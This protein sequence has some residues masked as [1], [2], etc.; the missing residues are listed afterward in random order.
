MFKVFIIG[1]LYFGN[2]KCP[3]EVPSPG[4]WTK[5][6]TCFT[7]GHQWKNLPYIAHNNHCNKDEMSHDINYGPISI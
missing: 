2:R 6:L 7:S 1:Q 4:L 3:V 5:K